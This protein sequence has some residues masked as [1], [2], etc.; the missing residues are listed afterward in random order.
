MK[1]NIVNEQIKKG[2]K[3]AIKEIKLINEGKRTGRP[4][5]EVVQEL[6]EKRGGARSG[7]GRKSPMQAKYPDEVKKR[8][9]LRLYPTQLK[10]IERKYGSL[11]SAVDGLK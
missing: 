1:E 9:T 8:V 3:Q 10:K 5:R 11:Q 7:A 6:I 4:A 2:L